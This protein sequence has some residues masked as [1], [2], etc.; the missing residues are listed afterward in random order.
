M[1][2]S[3]DLEIFLSNRQKE[4]ILRASLVKTLSIFNSFVEA[5]ILKWTA[6]DKKNK[7]K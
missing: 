2:S 4:I 5:P 3:N 1:D 6:M 7:K